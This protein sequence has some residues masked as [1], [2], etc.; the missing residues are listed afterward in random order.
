MASH[1]SLADYLLTVQSAEIVVATPSS[2]CHIS[3]AHQRPVELAAVAQ[4]HWGREY[5]Y[6]SI[7]ASQEASDPGENFRVLPM[8]HPLMLLAYTSPSSLLLVCCLFPLVA[9]WQDV[10]HLILAH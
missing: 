4:N 5:P 2:A 3:L 8:Q 10:M 9:S 1:I 7:N 6:Q